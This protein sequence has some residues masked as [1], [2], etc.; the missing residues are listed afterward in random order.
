MTLL[1][2]LAVLGAHAYNL[3]SRFGSAEN[4]A[5]MTR[6][7]D[8]SGRRPGGC[9]GPQMRQPDWPRFSKYFWW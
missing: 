8:R 6:A 2:V 1:A 4:A 3:S 9:S 5:D 7:A